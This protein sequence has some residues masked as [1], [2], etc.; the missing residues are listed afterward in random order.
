[1]EQDDACVM[2]ELPYPAKSMA[3]SVVIEDVGA[4]EGWSLLQKGLFL[5]VIV[6]CIA[7]YLRMSKVNGEIN[8]GYEKSLA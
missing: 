2:S 5:V 8:H 7:V 3:V 6:G 1:M 4:S